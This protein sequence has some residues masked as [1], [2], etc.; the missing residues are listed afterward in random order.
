MDNPHTKPFAVLGV[1]DPRGAGRATPTSI[2]LA[3]AFT[4]PKMMKALAKV[5]FTQSYTYFTWRNDKA[6]ADGVPHG[7]HPDRRWREYF[8]GNF[9]ANTPDILHEILQHGGRAGLQDA[10]GAG[11]DALVAATASTAATSCA[12]TTPRVPGTEEYLDSEKYE[13]K[14]RD[15]NAPGQHRRTHRARST[16]IRRENPALH[17]LPQPA[18]LRR[19][20]ARTSSSTAR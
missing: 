10:P 5:G 11:R 3:E 18:L 17:A 6:G 19:R 16:A 1:A 20:R 2:F 15:W 9:F 14:V 13:I 8:R 7:A 12:R 4:R